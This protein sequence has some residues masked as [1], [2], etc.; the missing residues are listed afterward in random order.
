MNTEAE[1]LAALLR[2]DL[3]SV[4]RRVVVLTKI[5]AR[6]EEAVASDNDSPEEDTRHGTDRDT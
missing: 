5:A 3:K 6:L 1:E 4:R 2:A